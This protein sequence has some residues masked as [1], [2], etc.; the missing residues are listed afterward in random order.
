[1]FLAFIWYF[2]TPSRTNRE[3]VF[4]GIFH[5]SFFCLPWIER[6]WLHMTVRFQIRQVSFTVVWESHVKIDNADFFIFRSKR[7]YTS[8]INIFDMKRYLFSDRFLSKGKL[9]PVFCT[10]NRLRGLFFQMNNT[11]L[12]HQKDIKYLVW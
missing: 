9:Y 3:L 4:Y 1:M 10:I 8:E 5:N 12:R 11:S 2:L 7:F 6:T